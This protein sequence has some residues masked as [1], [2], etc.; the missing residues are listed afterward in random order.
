MYNSVTPHFFKTFY[1]QDGSSNTWIFLPYTYAIMSDRFDHK[2]VQVVSRKIHKGGIDYIALVTKIVESGYAFAKL[3]Q[4]LCD[5]LSGGRDEC[6]DELIQDSIAE[7][8]EITQKAHN[9]A[10]ATADMFNATRMKFTKVRRSHTDES[11]I[12]QHL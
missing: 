3:A 1:K 7:M 12:R 4:E 10:K 5:T 6:P 9:D 2:D 8:Q 11:A